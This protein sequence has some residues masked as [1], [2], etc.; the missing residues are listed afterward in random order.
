MSL[1]RKILVATDFSSHSERALEAGIELAKRLGAEL[2]LTHAY[3]LPIPLVAP[4]EVTIPDPYIEETRKAAREK[5][6]E[7]EAKARAA[8]LAPKSELAEGSAAAAILR[9]A[10]EID[11]DLI[12]MGT[13]GLTGLKY[14]VL[15]SVAGHVLRAAPC[16][17][18]T[19][20]DEREEKK[21]RARRSA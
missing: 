21:R 17:V 4:Y 15:G 14:V 9:T 2:H 20:R 10:E 18:L 16:P 3:S 1:P 8:G 13:R 11:A 5:L 12:V 19:L 7:A 6:A